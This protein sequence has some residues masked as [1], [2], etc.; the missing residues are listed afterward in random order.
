VPAETAP[1]RLDRA[2]SALAAE[3]HGVVSRPQLA[4]LGMTRSGVE[5]RVSAGRLIRLHR[6]VYAVGH[7]ALR[8]EGHWQAAVLAGGPGAVL[9]HRSAAALWDLRRTASGRVD[10]VVPGRNGRATRPG[11]R[12]HRPMV[13]PAEETTS[14][15]NIRVTAPAR[16]LV[17]LAEV[18]RRDA[19]ERAVEQSQKIGLFDLVA[20]QR[21]IE[22]Q[23]GRVGAARLRRLLGDH[24]LTAVETRSGNERRFLALCDAAGVPRPRVNR[25]VAG[26]TVDFSW[27]EQRVVVEIDS[28]FHHGPQPAFERDRR[29][30]AGLT[31]AGF[32]ILRFTERALRVEA[33]RVKATLR[34]VVLGIR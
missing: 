11:L 25:D 15:R 34:S 22:R 19:L 26:F 5:A 30:D 14:V 9:S 23:P 29:R 18:V 24:Y 6:G 13:L 33:S 20:F 21:V 32:S 3:Q 2:V 1:T 17:D 31:I 16:T 8:A 28:Y 27:L 7:R 4:A 10:V 12:I